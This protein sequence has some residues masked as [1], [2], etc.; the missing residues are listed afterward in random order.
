MIAKRIFILLCVVLVLFGVERLM[1][2]ATDGFYLYKVISPLKDQPHWEIQGTDIA[3]ANALLDQDFYYLGSGVQMYAFLGSDGETV[4]KLFKFSRLIEDRWRLTFQG[5][6][7]IDRTKVERCFTSV[8]L[9]YMR[10]K[11]RCGLIYPHLT[12]EK[13]RKKKV[14]LF[15]RIGLP[16]KIDVNNVPFVLQRKAEYITKGKWNDKLLAAVIEHT[17]ARMDASLVDSDVR[18]C[19]NLGI[20]DGNVINIDIG[21]FSEN[22]SF[23]DSAERERELASV[24]CQISKE[25]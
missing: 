2:R 14:T 16:I 12:R 15:N 18:I 10:F 23:A 21:S 7:S 6:E 20:L 3:E 1:Y 22:F 25:M 24:L 13:I 8:K 4:L 17:E 5:E 19:R 9:A 11:E